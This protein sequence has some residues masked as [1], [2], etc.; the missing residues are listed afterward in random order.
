VVHFGLVTSLA[1]IV[2]C[3]EM[4]L[5]PEVDDFVSVFVDDILIMSR[6]YEEHLEHLDIVFRKLEKANL[7]PNK[8]TCEFFKTEV[9]FLGHII[10]SESIR[11]DPDKIENIMNSP[12]PRKTTDV[13]AFL[14]L[15]GY[16]RRN[17]RSSK[18]I[19]SVGQN[20]FRSHKAI[21]SFLTDNQGRT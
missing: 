8:E 19:T 2:R 16:Y 18:P 9:K 3:L 21:S 13:R 4:A 10:S 6:S 7:V 14:G 11:T 17:F 5:G 12:T 20:N 1:A 15:T